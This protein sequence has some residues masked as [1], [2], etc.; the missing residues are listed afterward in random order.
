M[1]LLVD[2]SCYWGFILRSPKRPTFIAIFGL[3]ILFAVSNLWVAAVRSTIPLALEGRVTAT[4]RRT[5]KTP[6]VDDVYFVSLGP[7][8]TIQVDAPV[9][10]AVAVGHFVRKDAWSS[11]LQING[12]TVPLNW[13]QD[14]RGMAIAMPLLLVVLLAFGMSWRPA[15]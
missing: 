5:E 15:S 14:L 8:R 6:G 4:E 11:S 10:D 3:G 12:M 9:F 2:V 7:T 1:S 13:S